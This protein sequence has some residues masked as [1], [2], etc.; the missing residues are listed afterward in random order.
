MPY[1]LK[2]TKAYI[3]KRSYLRHRRNQ[4]ELFVDMLNAYGGLC[5]CCGESSPDFLSL[6]HIDGGGNKDRKTTRKL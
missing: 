4:L 3:S 5:K 2:H 6:D 1:S